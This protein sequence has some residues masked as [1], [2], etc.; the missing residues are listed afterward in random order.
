MTTSKSNDNN[1]ERSAKEILVFNQERKGGYFY[2]ATNGEHPDK[3]SKAVLLNG[4]KYMQMLSDLN[5][6]VVKEHLAVPKQDVA[7]YKL[8]TDANKENCTWELVSNR[9][10]DYDIAEYDALVEEYKVLKIGN[11]SFYRMMEACTGVPLDAVRRFTVAHTRTKTQAEK[12]KEIRVNESG[13]R[14]FKYILKLAKQSDLRFTELERNQ[15]LKDCREQLGDKRQ[16]LELEAAK[17]PK[18]IASWKKS[19]ASMD[20]KGRYDFNQPLWRVKE[21]TQSHWCYFFSANVSTS[22]ELV[23]YAKEHNI[24]PF[25]QLV[26]SDGTIKTL[27][28]QT[29][30]LRKK[31]AVMFDA[32][33]IERLDADLEWSPLT[34]EGGD[35]GEFSELEIV[36]EKPETLQLNACFKRYGNN[37]FARYLVSDLQYLHDV[38]QNRTDVVRYFKWCDQIQPI[39]I[40]PKGAI[41]KQVPKSQRVKR[42]SIAGFKNSNVGA[43][44][45]W[46]NQ[47]QKNA[48]EVF[49]EQWEKLHGMLGMTCSELKFNVLHDTSNKQ[50]EFMFTAAD[51]E[52]E[53]RLNS[54]CNMYKVNADDEAKGTPT[55]TYHQPKFGC[56]NALMTLDGYLL[57]KAAEEIAVFVSRNELQ[58]SKPLAKTK[59]EG[60]IGQWKSES[61]Q[62]VI[63]MLAP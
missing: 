48:L 8:C 24:E 56:D 58:Y 50:K 1:I 5:A 45:E 17:H 12:L 49:K 2:L 28:S 29:S 47:C 46:V 15:T 22:K 26:K 4:I 53:V 14:F 27:F 57:Q 52:P 44:T 7:I 40:L 21:K 51:S 3:A 34:K 6:A 41:R 18:L 11:S 42:V 62:L 16:Y 23:N 25:T 20:I 10:G 43:N 31:I 63:Q 55:I 33:E 32:L 19:F 38:A 37:S 9:D 60:D 13:L 59:L 39:F 54:G 35:A 30:E 36:K 61:Q